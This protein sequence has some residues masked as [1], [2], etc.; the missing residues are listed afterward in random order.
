MQL[1]AISPGRT[2]LVRSAQY[3]RSVRPAADDSTFESGGR[4][5]LTRNQR[6]EEPAGCLPGVTR[7]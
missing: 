1:H 7:R 3:D 6:R 2:R 5:G 4:W